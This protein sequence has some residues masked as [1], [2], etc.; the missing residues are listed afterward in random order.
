MLTISGGLF[1]K[2][3]FIRQIESFSQVCQKFQTL[4]L[5]KSFSSDGKNDPKNLHK[6]G[7]KSVKNDFKGV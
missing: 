7:P 4:I 6:H 5:S 2:L 3:N 1:E